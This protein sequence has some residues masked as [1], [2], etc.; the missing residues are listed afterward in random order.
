MVFEHYFILSEFFRRFHNYPRLFLFLLFFF[1]F[2]FFSSS[3]S[4]SSFENSFVFFSFFP[5]MIPT[6][7][8]KPTAQ[9]LNSLKMTMLCKIKPFSSSV[10]ISF[11]FFSLFSVSLFPS[12]FSSFFLSPRTQLLFCSVH[13]S[14][15]EFVY[16]IFLFLFLLA[17]LFFSSS[18]FFFISSL[19]FSQFLSFFFPLVSLQLKNFAHSIFCLFA[20]FLFRLEFCFCFFVDKFPCVFFAIFSHLFCL[21]HFVSEAPFLLCVSAFSSFFAG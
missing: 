15:F 12:S 3:S 4:S 20:L 16:V 7:K 8:K 11:L 19:F 17:F 2:F 14:L 5:F 13:L 10:L 9:N 21:S 6:L 1:L 18:S